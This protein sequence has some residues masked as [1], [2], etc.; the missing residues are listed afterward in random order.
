MMKSYEL[1]IGSKELVIDIWDDGDIEITISQ[2]HYGWND[3]GKAIAGDIIIPQK[4]A[5][6][7]LEFLQSHLTPRG[8][9]REAAG[10]NSNSG[11]A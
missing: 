5:G 7:L 2:E 4:Y 3:G 6:E 11:V 9:D 1:E 10:E 8:S